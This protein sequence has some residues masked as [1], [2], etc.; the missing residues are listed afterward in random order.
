M[1]DIDFQNLPENT[2]ILAFMIWSPEILDTYFRSGSINF[3][4]DGS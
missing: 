4:L 1:F 3:L 2:H